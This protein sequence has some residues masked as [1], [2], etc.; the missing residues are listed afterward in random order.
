MKLH[1]RAADWYEAN[2]SP[3]M[4][5]EHLLSTTERD[6]CVQLVT[7]LVAADLPG[8]P[9]STV[10]RWLSALGDA[11]IEAYP[12]LAVLAG[13]VAR[14]T[15][16][17]VEAQRWAAIVDAAV[18]RPGAGRRH[19]V[20]RRR[21]GPCCAPSCAPAAPSRRW[22]TPTLAVAAEPPW[23][24]WRDTGAL[25][26]CGGA[27]AGRRRRPGRG[28]VRGVRRRRPRSSGTPTS[29]VVSEAELALLG[30]GSGPVGGGGRASRAWRSRPST[31]TGCTTT[32]RACSPFAGA[33]RLA[34]HEG[35]LDEANR[36]LT[37]AMRARPTCTF[38]AAVPRRA[39]RGCSWPRCTGRSATTTTARHLLREIDDILLHRPASACW[40]TRSPSFASMVTSSAPVGATGAR[41]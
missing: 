38:V 9:D 37:L 18:V 8:R 10:Q 20:V 12:P 27:P 22:P 13:W 4:A 31:S 29:L 26:V 23:S 35:D 1:L 36:Q 2:G 11:A 21:R 24:P 32:S 16:Q 6:R 39:R 33:A 30:D 28:P 5:V 41:R 15:G 17:T 34:V 25:R 19:G 14:S 40:S 3:A 7:V